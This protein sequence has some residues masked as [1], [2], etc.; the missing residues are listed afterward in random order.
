MIVTCQS[1]TRLTAVTSNPCHFL[2]LA[3][4]PSPCLPLSHNLR[5]YLNIYIYIYAATRALEVCDYMLE[6]CNGPDRCKTLVN[7]KTYQG[8]TPFI[9]AIASAHLPLLH[10]LI[11]YGAD[12]HCVDKHGCNAAHEAAMRGHLNVCEYLY[13]THH[14][15]FTLRNK[16][17]QTPLD[18]AMHNQRTDVVDWMQRTVQLD[19]FMSQAQTSDDMHYGYH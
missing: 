2:L 12:P 9:W 14:V 16:Q 4:I 7:C 8:T 1:A 11:S 6:Q 10:K 15:D 5:A 19:D 17:G 18:F 3:T 13:H